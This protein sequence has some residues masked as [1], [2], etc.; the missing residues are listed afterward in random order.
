MPKAL[1]IH[2]NTPPWK[3]DFYPLLAQVGR[4]IRAKDPFMHGELARV[5]PRA[6]C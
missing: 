3:G 2:G 1:Y 5:L 4:V 6:R